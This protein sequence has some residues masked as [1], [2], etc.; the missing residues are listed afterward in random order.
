M[1]HIEN[2]KCPMIGVSDFQTQ[3]AIVAN[4]MH[5]ISNEEKEELGLMSFRHST[6]GESSVGGVA[7]ASSI[8]DDEE[9]AEDL[10]MNMPSLSRVL[11]N[12]SSATSTA[13]VAQTK[14]Y[15]N[16][17]PALGSEPKSKAKSK[18]SST[19]GPMSAQE[20]GAV[21]ETWAK[22]NFPNAP[23]TP[24]T[25]DWKQDWKP[26]SN[27]GYINTTNAANGKHGHFRLADIKRDP[28]DGHYH[29]PFDGCS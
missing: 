11:S 9:P 10:N 24:V 6:V 8:L 27:S 18:M 1:S 28:V 5:M 20:G 16:S 25:A 4:N 29:C 14:A 19:P 23:N 26:E 12:G 3:R 21:A 2:N 13:S 7:I 15:H 17:Y 22:H